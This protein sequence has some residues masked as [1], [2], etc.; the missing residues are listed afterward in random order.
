MMSTTH[1][2][3]LLAA[4]KP[5]AGRLVLAFVA[6]IVTAATEPVAPYC[7][8]L[9]LDHGFVQN[10]TFS[11]WLVP[12]IAIGLMTV[13]G[14]SIFASTY[15][16]NWVSANVLNDF[17]QKMF[18]KLI[19]VPTSYFNEHS[20]GKVIN[21]LMF[22][23]QQINAM[24]TSVFTSMIRSVLTVLGLLVWLFYLNWQLSLVTIILLPMIALVVR[25]VGRRLKVL[26]QETLAINAQLTQAVEETTRAQQVIK[27]FGGQDHEQSKF[28]SRSDNLRRYTM[29]TTR[30]F[31]STMPITQILTAFAIS[32]VVVV[33]LIQSSHGQM[34]VGEFVSFI[35]AMLML[36]TPLR[37]I[38][39]VNGPLQRGMAA[40]ESVFNLIDAPVER[41]DGIVLP[42]RTSG[43][44][45]FV[46]VSFTYPNQA[47]A[48]LNNINLHIE[49]G[50]TI[51]FVGM[52]GGGKTTLVNLLPEFLV[53]SAG[54]ILFDGQPISE[55]SLN[56]LRDQ[57]AMVSQHVVL[58]DDTVAANIAY[59]DKRPDMDRV[60]AAAN[61]AYFSEVVDELPNGYD[62]I[63]GYN[64]SR[65]SGGQRQRLAIARAIY[66][67]APLL[68]LDEATSAL[69]TESERVVQEALDELMKGRT[70]FVIAHRLS[71]I[72]RA[73]RIV[74]LSE[75]RIVEIGSHDELMR[76]EGVYASL[77]R[78]QFS[79]ELVTEQ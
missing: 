65:F 78:L 54:Q 10:P 17:R 9:L 11:L 45:D 25:L 61:A 79:G 8:Q 72:E 28:R 46:G 75:G 60:K 24:V 48:A 5:Y 7:L 51:A 39:D 56:S 70:S 21:A 42:T 67:D 53:P 2:G 62:T 73:S 52:S 35:T 68:L 64:G 23:V 38:A 36:L 16:M 55:I 18:E 27:I 50:E 13:R 71:T 47:K 58:F 32:I 22:E 31:A 74:V 77:Y 76:N 49:P 44:I 4:H 1:I 12:I 43:R 63:I 30:T 40:A 3:R 33:A 34:T 66:K 59:G 26:N 37:Q 19:S 15:M 6:M 69:D 20:I 14:A 41:R 29:R 57:I